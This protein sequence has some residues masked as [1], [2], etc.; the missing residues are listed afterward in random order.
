M[1]PVPRRVEEVKP[2]R[3]TLP[4]KWSNVD[5]RFLRL[6]ID[7]LS[8][9]EYGVAVRNDGSYVTT[10]G[11]EG[12]INL[13]EGQTNPNYIYKIHSHPN[14]TPPSVHDVLV[15]WAD[16]TET[17]GF[18]VSDKWSEVEIWG[19]RIVKKERDRNRVFD[20]YSE[21]TE[22]Q[23]Y[24][25]SAGFRSALLEPAQKFASEIG[26]EVEHIATVKKPRLARRPH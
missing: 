24:V 26:I 14:A 16:K 19:M 5:K 20:L 3:I 12:A 21:Y 2:L 1:L 23:K 10:R 17:M 8:S 9:V 4:Q 13:S 25:A 6:V 15:F 7:N 18:V 22:R 11:G